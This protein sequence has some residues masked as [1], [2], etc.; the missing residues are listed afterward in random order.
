MSARVG[1]NVAT[2]IEELLPPAGRQAAW[3]FVPPSAATC[4]RCPIHVVEYTDT[5]ISRNIALTG[6]VRGG[7]SCEGRRDGDRTPTQVMP[8]GREGGSEFNIIASPPRQAATAARAGNGCCFSNSAGRQGHRLWSRSAKFFAKGHQAEMVFSAAAPATD[9][10][11]PQASAPANHRSTSNLA[12]ARCIRPSG[13]TSQA[14]NP[15]F[16]SGAVRP[17][18]EDSTGPSL[19][20]SYPQHLFENYRR[21]TGARD[22]RVPTCAAADGRYRGD[23]VLTDL[24]CGRNI[25]QGRFGG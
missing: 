22:C 23:R 18:P 15:N 8:P 20:S 1:P 4:V 5:N 10:F 11:A 16:P 12:R 21:T 24:G 9:A 17:Q 13:T 3:T 6:Q 14:E 19:T 25:L 2:F 7:A